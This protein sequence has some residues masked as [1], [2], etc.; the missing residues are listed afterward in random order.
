MFGVYYM[1][2]IEILTSIKMTQCHLQ[3]SK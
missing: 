3:K 1:W 2:L